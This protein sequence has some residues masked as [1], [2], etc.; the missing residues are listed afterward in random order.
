MNAPEALDA[1]NACHDDDPPRGAELLRGID[2]AGLAADQW[3]LFAFL[4]NHVLAEKLGLMAEANE[5]QHRLLAA[6]GDAPAP[7]LLRQAAVAALLAGDSVAELAHAA[8][9]AAATG[10]ATAQAVE[11]VQLAAAALRVPGA[12]AGSAG[13]LTLDALAPLAAPHWQQASALDSAAA[14][15]CNN[16]ASDLAERP[17]AALADA[18]L[19]E[20][21]ARAAAWSQTFWQ[22]AGTWV[23]HERACYLRALVAGALGEAEAA[24]AHAL[25]GLALLDAHDSAQEQSVDRAFLEMEHGFACERLGHADEA[26]AAHARADALAADFGDAG[27]T[28]WY[29]QRVERNRLLAGL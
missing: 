5:R 15:Q 1:A 14:A 2:P 13:R 10:V 18:G 7:V 19:R 21:L 12:E 16:L 29:R 24:R 23:H 20:A 25:A 8:E 22:R 17:P 26:A 4:I 27:L 28:A 3:P 11:L 9:F 6:A